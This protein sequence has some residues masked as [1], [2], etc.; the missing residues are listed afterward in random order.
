MELPFKQ[1]NVLEPGLEADGDVAS[2]G[3][4]NALGQN[5]AKLRHHVLVLVVNH[6][7]SWA[8]LFVIH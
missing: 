3:V 7:N 5:G 1:E 6:L 2:T 8:G 4:N